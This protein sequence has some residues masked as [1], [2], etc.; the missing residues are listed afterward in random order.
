MNQFFSLDEFTISVLIF[1]VKLFILILFLIISPI[2]R[3]DYIKT[4]AF[5]YILSLG[6]YALFLMR[7]MFS[8]NMVIILADSLTLFGFF[9]TLL[10]LFEML[11]LYTRKLFMHV[12]G[13]IA[14]VFVVIF[15]YIY[16][17]STLR[18][19]IVSF[20][21]LI[22][23]MHF[24]YLVIKNSLENKD[25]LKIILGIIYGLYVVVMI[26]RIFSSFMMNSNGLN[27]PETPTYSLTLLYI[28]FFD[29][30]QIFIIIIY[31]VRELNAEL[32]EANQRFKKLSYIDNLTGINNNRAVLEILE[33]ELHNAD[34]TNECV[35]IV[36]LD[37]DNFKNVNDKYG[38]VFGD[39]V[40]VKL[41]DTLKNTIRKSDIVGRYGGEEFLVILPNTRVIDAKLFMDRIISNVNEIKW[42]D[43]DY[44]LMF[45]A[46]IFEYH[47]NH[48]TKDIRSLVDKAD[49]AMYN[50][51][52]N[53]K[54][55]VVIYSD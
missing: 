45:S 39:E 9:Y 50:A 24:C 49:Q 15:S 48:T 5:G 38:H 21:Y 11:N 17:S 36:L 51:K 41:A 32:T 43:K 26:L 1:L 2:Y 27:L 20:F 7:D 34:L 3:K 19:V 42:D 40:L 18:I 44:Q 25:K 33:A 29:L 55:R 6:G 31:V 23:S 12:S 22:S 30:L 8:V 52:N 53:G 35:S 54:N 28:I 13:A 47:K 16:P 4:I 37:I 14:V 10:G 46:G